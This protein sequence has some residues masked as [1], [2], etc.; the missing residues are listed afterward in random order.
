MALRIVIWG[1][2]ERTLLLQ[3]WRKSMP[4]IIWSSYCVR[5]LI[6]SDNEVSRSRACTVDAVQK[7]YIRWKKYRRLSA[8][9]P[10]FDNSVQIDN[11]KICPV[12]TDCFFA[13]SFCYTVS[14]TNF[15]LA[16]VSSVQRRCCTHTI[17][18]NIKWVCYGWNS[19]RSTE[20]TTQSEELL[21]CGRSLFRIDWQNTEK[22]QN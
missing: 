22:R 3:S 2:Q 13:R 17:R 9:A 8:A 10:Q 6:D 15:G 11:V 12:K 20:C 18:R 5:A 7:D 19:T 21:K 1:M 14:F 16:L 4:T